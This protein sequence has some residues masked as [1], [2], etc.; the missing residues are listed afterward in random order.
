MS[1]HGLPIRK[2]DASGRY[3]PGIQKETNLLVLFFDLM[4]EDSYSTRV[5]NTL[6]GLEQYLQGDK[7]GIKLEKPGKLNWKGS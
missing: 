2:V 6:L 5:T 3:I 4:N 7:F 1:A